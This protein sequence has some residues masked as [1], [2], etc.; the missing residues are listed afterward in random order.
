[1]PRVCWTDRAEDSVLAIGRYIIEQSLSRDRGLEVIA[2][3][4]VR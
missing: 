2:R 1:M 4:I 3:N